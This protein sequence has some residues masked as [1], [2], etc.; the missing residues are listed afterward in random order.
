MHLKLIDS[1]IASDGGSISLGFE[2]ET[3]EPYW[4]SLD[5][6]I[7]SS[8]KNKIF[9]TEFGETSLSNEQE[10]KLLILLENASISPSESDELLNV[11]IN[12]IKCR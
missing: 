11:M 5:K 6:G 2:T 12:F 9:T 7:E 8:S 10:K 3:N 1:A 4:V